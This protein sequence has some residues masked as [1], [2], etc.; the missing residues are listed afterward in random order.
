MLIA[1]HW[2]PGRL[3]VGWSLG[4]LTT[5]GLLTASG[6][7]YEYR[8]LS[9]APAS[10]SPARRITGQDSACQVD[11]DAAINIGGY[12][13][14][15][16]QPDD[17]YLRRPRIRPWQWPDG[18]REQLGRLATTAERRTGETARAQIVHADVTG[19]T[20]ALVAGHPSG[21][22]GSPRDDAATRWYDEHGHRMS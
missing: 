20:A 9:T 22:R 17:C 12:E 3:L 7:W 19:P 18:I 21:G 15:P 16:D 5:L 11:K 8:Q 4:V 1:S 13:I 6:G 2:Q 14:V 10:G